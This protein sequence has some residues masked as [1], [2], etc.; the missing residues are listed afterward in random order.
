MKK[1]D[2]QQDSTSMMTLTKIKN[3]L[4]NKYAVK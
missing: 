4:T 1:Y 3:P 2:K